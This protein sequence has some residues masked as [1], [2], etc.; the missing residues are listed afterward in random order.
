MHRFLV[1]GE[2][3]GEILE[4]GRVY[5]VVDL[6]LLVEWVAGLVKGVAFVWTVVRDGRWRWKLTVKLV[7]FVRRFEGRL[8]VRRKEVVLGFAG[9]NVD[10]GFVVEMTINKVNGKLKILVFRRILTW[11]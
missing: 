5:A 9:V 6:Q 10:G 1:P 7:Q 8:E 11:V 2:D 4:G 3:S